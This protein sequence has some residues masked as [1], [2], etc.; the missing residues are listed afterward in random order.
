[1]EI[2]NKSLEIGEI[3]PAPSQKK[4]GSNI[5]QNTPKIELGV[6]SHKIKHFRPSQKTFSSVKSV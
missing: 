4:W 6:A 3:L 2:W 1:V 5:F